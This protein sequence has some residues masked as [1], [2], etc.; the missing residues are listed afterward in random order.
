MLRKS[1]VHEQTPTVG[2]GKWD[3][4]AEF[5]D[6]NRALS[7]QILDRPLLASRQPG[8]EHAASNCTGGSI[9]LVVG[10]KCANASMSSPP[11]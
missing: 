10:A 1:V 11:R 6:R 2:I 5:L 7:L 4:A 3:F 8:P 9:S